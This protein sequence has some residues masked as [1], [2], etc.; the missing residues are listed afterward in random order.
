MKIGKGKIRRIWGC[1]DSLGMD[2]PQLRTLVFGLTESASISQLS[3]SQG[4]VVITH[5]ETLI[6]RANRN[7]RLHDKKRGIERVENW[8][9]SADQD[10]MIDDLERKI[11]AGS[12]KFSVED[13]C[14]RTFKKERERLNRKQAQA[15]IEA[16]K[17]ILN[18][19]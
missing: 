12:P 8:K 2:E 3:N 7:S 9:R 6:A 16:L 18:R 19:G 1:A 4:D 14:Q 11:N 10:A 13:V 15:L 5:M 17:N